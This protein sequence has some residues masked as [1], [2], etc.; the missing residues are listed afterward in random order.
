LN[1]DDIKEPLLHVE[2]LS[3]RFLIP[4]GIIDAIRRKEKQYLTAVD[5]VSL[6]V[7]RGDTLGLV[8][9]SG[10]GKST[11]AKTIIGLYKP[12]DGR[13]LF[14]GV[15]LTA[16][17]RNEL[18]KNC[19][20]I[21][22]VFQDPYSSLNP[23]MSVRSA[24]HE[25]LS[26][27]KVCPASEIDVR[28][29]ELLEMV[30]LTELQADRLPSSFSGG[31]RQRIGIARALALNPQIIIADEPVSALDVSIQAQ[32]VNLLTELQKK[33]GLT[34]LFISHDLRVVRYISTRVAVMYLGKIVEIGLTDDLFGNPMH[35]YTDILLKAAPKMTAGARNDKGEKIHG[36]PPSPI[37]L[38]SGCRFHPRC[39]FATE[40]CKAEI[41]E[42]KE[43]DP[44]HFC[45]CLHPPRRVN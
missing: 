14:D 8:G 45:A 35:P 13:V 11:L 40:A 30:G 28:I 9:E 43:I 17:S 4:Q 15:D 42:L 36:D 33:L 31:Q 1:G 10:C 20:N 18:R 22:M 44:G 7:Y 32:V 19:T 24:L 38:P 39:P 21:Q 41:P 29:K 2:D 34:L 3:T 27:H 12:S 23:R 26:V 5:H 16:M 6:D 37:Q 25:E